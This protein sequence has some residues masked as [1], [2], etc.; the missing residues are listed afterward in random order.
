MSRWIDPAGWETGALAASWR[1][2]APFPHLV[3]DALAAPAAHTE[4]LAAFDEEP[5]SRI[6]DEI[7]EVLASGKEVEHPAL[8]RF[9]RELGSPEL[10]AALG[11]VTGRELGRVEMRAYAFLP[12]DYLLPCPG[13]A[14]GMKDPKYQ[15]MV[16]KGPVVILTVLPAGGSNMGTNLIQWFFY[17]VVVSVFA[18]YV[19]GRAVAPGSSYLDAFRFAGV[20]AFAGYALALWQNAIWYKRSVGTTLRT[21]FDGLVY[22]LLTAGTFGWLWPN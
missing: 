9:Q 16:K 3:V 4:L 5:A 1:A 2:A 12:G 11:R 7:F 19:T 15:E 20:T 8:R 17:C 6:H 14:A 10:R 13:G 21:S 18:A 22:A